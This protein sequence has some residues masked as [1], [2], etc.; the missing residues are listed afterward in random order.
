MTIDKFVNIPYHIGQIEALTEA[1][2]NETNLAKPDPDKIAG[3]TRTIDRI[4][5]L[6]FDNIPYEVK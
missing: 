4:T 2:R 3:W 1:I 5:E 6:I